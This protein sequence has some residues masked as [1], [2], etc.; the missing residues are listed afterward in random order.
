[1]KM[2]LP[3][4]W[5]AVSFGQTWV[6]QAGGTSASLRGVSA[7]NAKVVWA[8]GSGGTW[9]RTVDGGLNW[10][11]ATVPGAEDLDFRGVRAI[12]DRTAYLMSSG[13]GEK[14]RVFKTTDA[15]SH[16]T[17]LFTNP[18][19]GGFFDAIAFWDARR[20]IIAGDPVDG[21]F[22]I[23]TTEDEGRNWL[24]R[25]TPPALPNEGSFAASNSCL[26]VLG[27]RDAWVAT[28]GASTARIMHSKNGGQDW[29][30]A[31]TPVR[32]DGASSGIFSLAFSGN[33]FSG[34]RRGIAV[35][36]D[37][38]KDTET[39]QN[40]AVTSDGGRTWEATG[41]AGPNG[42]RS[43]VAYLAERKMWLATGTS[44]SDISTDNG[45]VWKQF[46]AGPYNALSE[47]SGQV[48]AVGPKGRIGAL[49]V[50]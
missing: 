27:T 38:T 44:G 28:G 29:A 24:R 45:K 49:R 40:I 16:W 17:L 6:S 21:H 48:W 32:S 13:P 41:S 20:G 35:G 26:V 4:F 18:D 30:V 19:A 7:W 36:G 9:L 47:V 46:D 12:D 1:M 22:A 25:Q 11:A 39:R 23:F 43:A 10:H 2:V 31:A 5:V 14:S 15:G 42:F 33:G 50:E 37:Y 34:K 8:S 3:L